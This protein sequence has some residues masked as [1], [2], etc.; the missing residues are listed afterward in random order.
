ME[1]KDGTHEAK[2]AL[3]LISTYPEMAKVFARFA[4]KEGLE[5]YIAFAALGE[6]AD[7][8]REI[9]SHTDVILSRGGTADYIR[10]AVDIPVVSIPITSFDAVR[11]VYMIKDRAREIGFFNYKQKM[12]GISEIETMFGLKIRE[13]TFTAERDIHDGILDARDKGVTIVIGGIVTVRLAEK[14]GLEGILI[15]CGEEA[16]HRSINEAIHLAE[17]RRAER[18]RAARFKMVL[19]SIAEGIIVTDEQ[20]RVS[21]YNPSAERIFRIPGDEV[22]GQKVQDV[23]PNTRMHIVFERGVPELAELQKVHGGVIATNRIPITLDGRRIGVVSTFEDV[24]KIQH[25]EQVIRKKIYAKGFV[26]KYRFVDILTASQSM[27]ELKELAALYATTDSAVLIQG[28]S[29]TGKELFAQSIH[30]ASRR[31]S[32]PFVAVNCAAIPEHLLESELFGYEGGAFTG[33]KR[34]G[35]QGLFELAHKG[36]IFLDEIGELPKAL[37]SRLLRVVQEKEIMRI[38]G[39]KIV[40]VDIRIISAT[41][42]DL[43]LKAGAGEF[44]D[45]LYYR[46]NVFNL[47]I[48]PLRARKDDILPLALAFLRRFHIKV[49]EGGAARDLGPL[50]TAYEWPG[51][52]RELYSVMERL[53][54]L[55]RHTGSHPQWAQMLHKV[56][57]SPA[58]GDDALTIRVNFDHGLKQA[59]SQVEKAIV[60]TMLARHGH[61]HEQVARLLGVGRTTLWRKTSR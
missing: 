44:R 47:K 25:L 57:R 20:N 60:D 33:A 6:A 46:L 34:E 59:V 41:N 49:D 16:V 8:A 51:N 52:V 15:E 56:M 26:A 17:V 22:V 13:Y 10:E 32:G 61:D 40:P 55:A 11:S 58:A 54:L 50:L 31:S 38:G 48:P 53:S 30:N 18:S 43:E 45:D 39:D 7:I 27:V 36:S 3:A 37:Q 19:D 2:P 14:F 1:G 28:E 9:E 23:I 29:G 12:H 24:T 4:E 35:K 5:P 42:K 21:I